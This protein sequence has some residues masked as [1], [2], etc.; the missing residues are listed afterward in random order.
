[1]RHQKERRRERVVEFTE[2]RILFARSAAMAS[3]NASDVL[4]ET[5]ID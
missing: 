3:P 1:M 2:G 4:V 5:L